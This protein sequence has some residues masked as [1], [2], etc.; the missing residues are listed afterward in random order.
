MIKSGGSIVRKVFLG[1][2]TTILV[3]SME[4]ASVFAA[5][6]G[7]GRNYVDADNDGVCDYANSSCVYVDADGDGLCDGCGIYHGC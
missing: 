4:T 5:G 6:P 3:F 7:I 1:A 2:L